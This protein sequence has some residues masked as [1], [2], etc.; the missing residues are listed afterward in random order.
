M[1]EATLPV[2]SYS[3]ELPI[4]LRREEIV[5]TIRENQV[6][7]IA[8]ETG[9]GKTTQIPKFLLECGLGKKGYLG[10]TQPR[11]VAALSVA[12]RIAEELGVQYGNQVGAKIRFTDQTQAN[13]V[14]KVMTDGILLNELQDDPMLRAYEAI[15]IDEAH[16]RSLNIDFILGCL[17]QLT[18]TRKD[19][20]IIITSATIDTASFAKAFDDAPI[21][22]VSGRMYPVDTFYRPPADNDEGDYIDA[23]TD[24]ITE[25]IEHNRPGDILVFLPGERDIHE[26]RRQLE[27]SP[28]RQCDL[29]PLFGRL[30]NADQQ[31][32]FHPGGR[33]RIILSTNIAET[34]LTVPGIR[35]VVDTGLARVS[36]YSPHSRTQRLPI[37]PIA[38]SS[39]NQRQGRCGRVSNG[40]CYRLYD[41]Q[42]FLARPRYTTPEIHRS[43]LASVI[44]RMMAFKLGD[45]RTF[46]FIDPPAENAIVGGYRLLA[47]LGAVQ[48][49]ERNPDPD[50]YRLTK[51]G[52]RLA[53]L[54]VDPTV[55]R[56]LLQAQREG[57]LPE[58]LVIASGLSIQDPRERPAEL[59]KEADEMHK[60][61]TH[62][63][64]DFLTL[65]NIWNSY[66]EKLDSL[67][68]NKLRKFC[69][70]HFLAYQRMREWRDI[71]HQLERILKERPS[72]KA[73]RSSPK[74]QQASTQNSQLGVL[75]STFSPSEYAA[76]HRSILTGL[77]SNIAHKEEEH[78]YRGPRNR[79]A[80]LFPGSALFDHETAKKQ[81]KAAYAKK[82]KPKPAKTKAPEW[83]V[84]GEW[85]E[86]SRLF[87]RTAAKIEVD[88]IEEL[89]GDLL[90]I[91]HSE[92]FWS[93]KGAAVLSKERRILFGLE[94]QRNQVSYS[95]IN[96][97]EATDIFIRNGLIEGGIK[98]RPKFFQQNA[99]VQQAAESELARRRSGSTLWIE[100]QLFEFYRQRLDAVGSFAE[101]RSYAKKHHGGSLDFLKAH[102]DDLLPPDESGI[103]TEDF[104]RALRLGGSEI[105]LQYRNEPGSEEDGVTLRLPLAQV[106]AIQQGTLDWAV[107]GHLEEKIECLLR[108]L[109][110]QIRIRLHPL[111]ERASELKSKLKPSERPLTEQLSELLRSA[112][113]IETYKDQWSKA[114]LPQHLKPRIQIEN[115]KGDALA[116][117]RDLDNLRQQLKSKSQQT[118]A[119]NGLD[120]IPAWQAAAAQHERENLN[121]W[122]F[123]N[124]PEC[125]DLS[126][127][128]G[129]PLK[130][131]PALVSERNQIHLRLCPDRDQARQH[132]AKAW[133]ELAEQS[134]GREI[135]WIRRDLKE[136]KKLGILLI[137]LGGYDR[138]KDPAWAHLRRH[139]FKTENLLPLREANFQK[140][141]Q[142]ANHTSK[143]ITLKLTDHL[144]A[145][146]EARE[147]V[148]LLLEQ[149]KT[150]QAII[151]PGMR[152][153]LEQ[154]APANLLDH[155]EFDELQHIARYLKAMMRRAQ[156]AKESIQRDI[157]KSQ[158]IAPFENKLT[159]LETLA[160]KAQ[161]PLVKPYR[162]LLEE[163]RVSIY[164]QELGTAQKVSEKRL[165]QLAE[166]ITKQLKS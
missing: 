107:P 77:L 102:E 89:A 132:T 158:R 3:E 141:L 93:S 121:T 138:I 87:A 73:K 14:I 56:M 27:D 7:V 33:R 61:F 19:L 111:K 154:I 12:Q 103:A 123:G 21:I 144:R 122:N 128:S 118:A 78:T 84:C 85:M 117:S 48:A 53:Q 125:I 58:V 51:L 35:Y 23:A 129:L 157:E 18:H 116:Q 75:P 81:R 71:H 159:A 11:R 55:A 160:K 155:Y 130:A 126:G 162:I 166:A 120:A 127:E 68:Q 108:A 140:T 119:G 70:S 91:R 97:E 105:P 26:L 67:S 163:F 114:Q 149:K 74:K 43:N 60:Q 142:H 40:V 37:E 46:P 95:R 94:I 104:P 50:A 124:P 6:V 109:P 143:G 64:S 106:D 22:E 151:Y 20:K 29:L 113:G 45:I 88:W 13:T 139:L 65:L 4:H 148:Q 2:P 25:I 164:A 28:A 16:E 76:I 100:D 44:L 62:P 101:L 57:A 47:E 42:D 24:V 15:V 34:S 17:R 137:Q 135:A 156:R 32:I 66:H 115:T 69:K 90:S 145:I 83:I 98:E 152:A 136:L 146:L 31:R 134:M 49:D 96:P 79:K 52:R 10:C 1:I 72:S 165:E 41:E 9:S 153:H 30:A 80:L 147:A 36:R 131:Y 59:A 92:P 63:E 112:Y 38:Q 5:R 99:Q 161:A 110:K 86:T 150:S 82:T 39:A 133:P 54:P 8:G